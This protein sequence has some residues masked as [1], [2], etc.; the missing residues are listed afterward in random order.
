M[1]KIFI[2][3]I[4]LPLIGLSGC[5]SKSADD[6]LSVILTQGPWTTTINSED[7]DL[8]GNYVEFGDD[9]EKDDTWYFSTNGTFEQKNGPLSCDGTSLP[10]EIIVAGNWLFEDNET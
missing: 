4:L 6:D 3:G 8:D 1:K 7:L 9:C 2:L 10:S 5:S